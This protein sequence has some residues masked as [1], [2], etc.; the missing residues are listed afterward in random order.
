M[1]NL[2]STYLCAIDPRNCSE[3]NDQPNHHTNLTSKSPSTLNL[4][5]IQMSPRHPLPSLWTNI[6]AVI[7]LRYSSRYRI[8]APGTNTKTKSIIHSCHRQ[9]ILE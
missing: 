4:G 9:T 5:A 2:E 3:P 8:V 6:A 7:F 1:K